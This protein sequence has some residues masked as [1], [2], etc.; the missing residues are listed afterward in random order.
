[1]TDFPAAPRGHENSLM[2]DGVAPVAEAASRGDAAMLDAFGAPAPVPSDAPTQ[3][4]AAPAA[5]G[6]LASGAFAMLGG[7]GEVCG[8]DGCA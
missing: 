8:P 6:A 2:F 3:L 1:M 5:P 4:F 7:T